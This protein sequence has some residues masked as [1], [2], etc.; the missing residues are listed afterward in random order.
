M[1]GLL[2][3]QPLVSV[4]ILNYNGRKLL[5]PCLSSVL[6]S[7]YPN[8]EIIFVDNGSTDGSVEFVKELTRD[9]P[10]LKII[11]NP[12]NLGV[13]EGLNIGIREA[14]GKYI[15][16]LNNDTEVEPRWL[17]ELVKVLESD[18]NVG[19]AQCKLLLHEDPH[20]IDSA[21]CIIDIYGYTTEKGRFGLENYS[22]CEVDKGQYDKLEEIFSAGCPASIV[23]RSVLDEV[24]LFDPK[25]FAGYEDADLSWRIRLMGYKIVLAPK[26]VV[27]HKRG[28]TSSGKE[29][30]QKVSFN[31]SKNRIAMLI[32]N[33]SFRTLIKV[34]PIAVSLH[35]LSSLAWAIIEKDGELAITPFKAF[36]WNIKELRYL[37]HQ[38]EI[39]QKKIRRV[40]DDK[41]LKSM[42]KKCIL[43]QYYLKP[44]LTKRVS[45]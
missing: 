22:Y 31:F 38:R 12:K 9:Y 19:A 23:R 1:E 10:R 42:S 7:N 3:R 45:V 34:L 26:A 21:G 29:L 5:K 27:Y 17:S 15:V 32:K 37:L 14:N 35:F 40:S 25:F 36:L 41:I 28:M 11:Q 2:N 4:I 44:Y 43:I 33:Y 16:F 13:T 18:E 8:L 24:G 39:V 20:R 30:R 6:N